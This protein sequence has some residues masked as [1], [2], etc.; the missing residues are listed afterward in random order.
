MIP[1]TLCCVAKS[2]RGGSR[3]GHVRPA[4]YAQYTY[5]L[6]NLLISATDKFYCQLQNEANIIEGLSK[7][8]SATYENTDLQQYVNP[9]HGK[10]Y[11]VDSSSVTCLSIIIIQDRIVL[12]DTV[13]TNVG[14]EALF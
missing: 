4:G 13:V 12:Q 1:Y 8:L 14:I 6:Y 3:E 7:K 9:P 2:A 11:F 10:K 5:T